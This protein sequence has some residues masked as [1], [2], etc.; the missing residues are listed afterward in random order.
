MGIRICRRRAFLT[1]LALHAPRS[2]AL[3]DF[4]SILLEDL[5]S[6]EDL[7]SGMSIDLFVGGAELTGTFCFS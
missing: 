6:V 3:A 7:G 5:G 1:C 4:F 2:V